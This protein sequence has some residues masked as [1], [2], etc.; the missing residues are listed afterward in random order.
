MHHGLQ[1]IYF[2]WGWNISTWG[3]KWTPCN[4][5]WERSV[6]LLGKVHHPTHPHIFPSNVGF[7]FIRAPQQ[8][9]VLSVCNATLPFINLLTFWVAFSITLGVYICFSTTLPALFCAS[10]GFSIAL[11]GCQ[12]AGQ[13]QEAL[14]LLEQMR[15]A[16]YHRFQG[17]K[18]PS[19]YPW[20]QNPG[21]GFK[22]FLSPLFWE[23]SHFD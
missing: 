20:G 4:D 14:L 16:W 11:S 8:S 9:L 23:D 21:G 10:W 18:K 5:N 2:C 13:W 19:N 6:S 22:H 7:W 17:A 1:T 3:W 12:L 15:P